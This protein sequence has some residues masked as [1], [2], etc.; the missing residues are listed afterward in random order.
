MLEGKSGICDPM[1]IKTGKSK[2]AISEREQFWRRLIRD[3]QLS[4]TSIKA[5]CQPQGVSQPSYFACLNPTVEATDYRAS[6][7]LPGICIGTSHNAFGVPGSRRS[8]IEAIT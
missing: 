8:V 7:P 2:L 5:F 1:L 4:G 3:Q 6:G